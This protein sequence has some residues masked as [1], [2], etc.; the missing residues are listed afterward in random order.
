MKSDY[1]ELS[2]QITMVLTFNDVT[3]ERIMESCGLTH[4]EYLALKGFS[5]KGPMRV[6]EMAKHLDIA[7]STTSEAC[8]VLSGMGYIAPSGKVSGQRARGYSITSLGRS[9]VALCEKAI[10]EGFDE[11]LLCLPPKLRNILD[12][13]ILATAIAIDRADYNEGG[14]NLW[15][16]YAENN[17]RFEQKVTKF[18]H[19]S[20]LTLREYRVLLLAS[21]YEVGARPTDLCEKLLMKK[22]TA[23]S[24]VDSLVKKDL[25]LRL[26]SP[27]DKRAVLVS[28]TSEGEGGLPW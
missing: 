23:K 15:S 13:G 4:R 25:A 21:E 19:L 10:A 28:V 26:P 14:F 16:A 17:S 22:T 27:G 2:H 3:S 6:D 11:L 7:K 1:P 20:Q 8:S 9:A 5:K 24:A 18:A 12:T